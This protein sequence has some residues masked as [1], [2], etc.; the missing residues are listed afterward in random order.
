MSNTPMM[1]SRM[2]LPLEIL[3]M[4]TPVNGAQASQKAQ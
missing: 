3:A 1:S 2:V 4:N